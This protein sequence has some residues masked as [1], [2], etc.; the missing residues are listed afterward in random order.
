M[1]KLLLIMLIIIIIPFYVNAKTCDNDKIS[2]SSITIKDK[3]NNVKELSQTTVNGKKIKIN[4]SM[5]EV[6]DNIEY[7]IIVKNDSNNDYELNNNSFNLSSKYIEYTIDSKDH[8]NIVKRKTSKAVSLKIEYKHEV[9]E[10]SFES[11]VYNDKNSIMVKLSNGD[12]IKNPKT[13][14]QYL[15]IILSI[16]ILLSVS[17]YVILDKKK[18]TKYMLLIIS[19]ATILPISVYALCNIEIIVQSSIKIVDTNYVETLY[20]VYPME[21]QLTIN[22]SI[23]DNTILRSN[24]NEAMADWE[25]L[26][27]QPRV[28]KPFYIKHKIQNNIVKESNLIFIVTEQIASENPGMVAGTY[29]L[30]GGYA[31]TDRETINHNL[32]IMY[33]AFDYE[34]HPSRCYDDASGD[35]CVVTGLH[36]NVYNLGIITSDTTDYNTSKGCVI[37]HTGKSYCVARNN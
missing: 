13:G 34:H 17:L 30:I 16:I 25:T 11:G 29:E 9:P 12:N 32:E 22:E 23:T 14:E 18:Y 20:G 21:N 7:N 1:K 19:L 5:K 4:L 27:Q 15:I 31:F 36:V 6:G 2:I 26:I 10:D 37:Y 35:H 24:P 3:S 8:S 28:T 33:E